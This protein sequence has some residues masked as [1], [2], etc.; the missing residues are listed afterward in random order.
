M[1]ENAPNESGKIVNGQD[2][3]KKVKAAGVSM[4][5][6]AAPKYC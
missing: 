1:G 2:S 3:W 4:Y 6:V 5:T